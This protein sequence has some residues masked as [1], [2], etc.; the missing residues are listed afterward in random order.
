MSN[1]PYGYCGMP[2]ALCSRYRTNGKSACPGCSAGGYYT[3]MCKVY[4]CAKLK[5]GDSNH[6]HCALCK[7]F[8]CDALGKLKDFRDLNTNN[9][10]MRT[11]EE[12][13]ERG[14][15]E[16]YSQYCRK[17]MLLTVALENYNDGRMKRFL[18]ELFIQN[19]E[20]TLGK[21][22]KSAEALEGDVKE[23]AKG[24]RERAQS[25]LKAEKGSSEGENAFG[26][27]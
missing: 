15:D 1:Y 14:F 21:I 23:K 17:A 8:I 26:K 7:D 16:W 3:D 5:T 4:R 19:D 9:V 2:C 18:C 22:M 11:L 27:D 20:Q 24:F 6:T 10:K 25:I 13:R 12:I